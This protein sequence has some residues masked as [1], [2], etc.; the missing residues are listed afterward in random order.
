MKK[1]STEIRKEQIKEAALEIIYQSG[2]NKFTT[3]RLAEKI[4]IS[5]ATIF[6]HFISKN[7]NKT[8]TRSKGHF[9]ISKGYFV[10]VG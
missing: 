6:R 10:M 1:Y 8:F 9:V 4:G 7:E 3:R 5:E 2:I